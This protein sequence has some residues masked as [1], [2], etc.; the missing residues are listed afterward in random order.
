[1][2]PE[3]PLDTTL[4]LETP[5]HIGFRHQL[6][7]PG[8]RSA[9]YLVDLVVRG[10]VLLVVG[11]FA[12]LSSASWVTG[13][14]GLEVGVL[15]VL[16][17]AMEW[18]YFVLF[19]VLF[20]GASPGKRA[21][22]L[23]VIHQEGRPLSF[24]ESLLRNLLRAA[25]L[26]PLLYAVGLSV[27]MFDP[28]FRRL[29]DLVAGTVV[30]YE[31]RI[32]LASPGRPGNSADVPGLPARPRLSAEER[33]AL[34]LFHRRLPYLSRARAEELAELLAPTFRRRYGLNASS[35]DLLEALYARATAT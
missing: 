9:A 20:A 13:F 28:R 7:G 35:V 15:L 33:A 3:Q 27:M 19:E 16:F 22:R 32:K 31:P 12:A 17:F 11:M 14:G 4:I 1:M 23:R 10:L 24:A 25:D 8:R 26:L 21:F 34:A 6:A 5:E 18:G 29:G 2:T 30:V